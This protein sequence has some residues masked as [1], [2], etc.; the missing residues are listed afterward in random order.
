MIFYVYLILLM[1][2]L[3]GAFKKKNSV[4]ISM[5]YKFLSEKLIKILI[6]Q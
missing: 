1:I 6:N 2:I 3:T 5:R 4:R